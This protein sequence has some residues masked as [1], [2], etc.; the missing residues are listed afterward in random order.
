[1]PKGFRCCLCLLLVFHVLVR[2]DSFILFVVVFSTYN[3][4]YYQSHIYKIYKKCSDDSPPPP[5]QYK[6]ILRIQLNEVASSINGWLWFRYQYKQTIEQKKRL[7]KLLML[8]IYP[9]EQLIHSHFIDK[10]G[11][12]GAFYYIVQNNSS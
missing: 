5:M 8:F 12:N 11:K 9:I 6:K 1:M 2:L 7:L 4:L 10:H 3:R